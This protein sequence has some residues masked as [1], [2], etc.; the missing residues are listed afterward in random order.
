LLVVR[1]RERKL[2]ARMIIDQGRHYFDIKRSD[3][4][5]RYPVHYTIGS[6]WEQAFATRL[7]NGEIHVFPIQYNVVEK[8]WANFWKIIDDPQSP[9][10]DLSR[11][12]DQEVW[13]SYQANCSVCH[14]SQLRNVKGNGF[15]PSNLDFRE[16]GVNCEMCHGPS[17]RHVE[18]MLRGRPY[19]KLAIDPPVDFTKITPRQYIAICSQCHLQSA[20]RE[21]GPHGELNYS[22]QGYFF[23]NY[24][25]RPYGEFSRKGF[26]KDGRFRQTTFIVESL[27]RSK[28]FKK[29]NVTC[30]NCHD[31]HGPDVASNPTSLRFRDHPD[32]MCLQCHTRYDGEIALRRHTHHLSESWGSRCFSCHMPRIMDALLFEARTHRIDDI[33]DAGMTLRFGQEESPNACLLCHHEKDAPWVRRQLLGWNGTRPADNEQA[34]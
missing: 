2:F 25:S 14:T 22:T 20:L 13:T 30:G 19:A 28:C 17:S 8:R 26:Y 24:R 21:P 16:P 33:P 6:K 10:A 27:M 29:G 9:R 18:S 1:G 12:E 31:P 5:H 15:E 32:Q 34:R 11:W 23:Q 4:W 3:G 7:T